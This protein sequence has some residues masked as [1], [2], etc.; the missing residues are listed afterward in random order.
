V[1]CSA[2]VVTP[3]HCVASNIRLCYSANHVE[4]NWI[5]S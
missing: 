3:V 4:M 5:L 2:S 1:E